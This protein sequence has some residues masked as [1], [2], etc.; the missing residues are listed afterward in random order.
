M[1]TD[2]LRRENKELKDAFSSQSSGFNKFDSNKSKRSAQGQSSSIK[3]SPR[4]LDYQT[5]GNDRESLKLSPVSKRNQ[6]QESDIKDSDQENI[7]P[8]GEMYETN[9]TTETPVLFLDVNFGNGSV[10]RIVM[11][12]NDTPEELAEAFCL[13]HNLD[14]TKKSKLIAIIKKHLDSVLTKIDENPNEE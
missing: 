7:R 5:F 8:E 2:S 13:E 11:Y 4:A 9:N 3:T 12:E 1:Y 6:N 14:L 10:T